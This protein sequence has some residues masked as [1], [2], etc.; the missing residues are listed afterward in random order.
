LYSMKVVHRDCK[1]DNL[2]IHFP[3]IKDG[4]T[5][6]WKTI[7]LDT[8]EFIIKIADFGYARHLGYNS[9]SE[10]W[11]GTPLLMAPEV[12]FGK[13]YGHKRDVWALG[14]MYYQLITGQYIFGHE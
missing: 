2:L 14:A 6:D 8:E 12:L 3:N 5:I 7:D 13:K 1:L 9:T 10:S 4:E 11:F